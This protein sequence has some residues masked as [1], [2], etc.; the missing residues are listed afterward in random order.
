MLSDIEKSIRKATLDHVE[1]VFGI[2]LTG[3]KSLA[4]AGV[5]Q[6]QNDYPNRDI[7]RQDIE[8]G[9]CFIMFHDSDP[10]ATFVFT[11]ERD[12]AYDQSGVYTDVSEYCSLHRVAV[13][14]N[15]KG[16]G[17][18]GDIVSFCTAECRKAGILALFC[19]THEHNS[20]M[21]RMLEKNGFVDKG[22]ISLLDGSPR[23]A[24]ELMVEQ[25]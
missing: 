16:L 8:L 14:P 13:L 5:D 4:D 15:C 19:D 3:K 18:G 10:V 25:K 22:A 2:L 1:T 11:K 21:R 9:D 20:S 17:V 12:E 6:W 23:V 7:I 24:Y